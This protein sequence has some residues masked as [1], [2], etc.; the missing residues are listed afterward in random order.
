MSSL[1]QHLLYTTEEHI[2]KRI[3]EKALKGSCFIVIS[4]IFFLT[5]ISIN[6]WVMRTMKLKDSCNNKILVIEDEHRLIQSIEEQLAVTN[7]EIHF[8][9]N[10]IEAVDKMKDV[11]PDLLILDLSLPPS[12]RV[13]EGIDLLKKCLR[14]EKEY[15]IFVISGKKKIK[16]AFELIRQGK[17]DFVLKSINTDDLAITVERVLY[18][19]YLEMT[20]QELNSEYRNKLPYSDVIE[21]SSIINNTF[22]QVMHAASMELNV[23][24]LGG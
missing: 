13:S 2:R 21:K 18:Q 22:E 3:M 11:N 20:L 10:K 1:V 9:S 23:L 15:K 7:A 8:A 17:D 6:H 16:D 19:N 12:Y 24:I 5:I 4:H 14:L